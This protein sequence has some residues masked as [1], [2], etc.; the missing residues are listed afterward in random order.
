MAKKESWGKQFSMEKPNV[1]SSRERGPTGQFSKE[2][3]DLAK[4]YYQRIFDLRERIKQGIFFNVTEYP[5]K[6]GEGELE[7]EY[8]IPKKSLHID[9]E[10]MEDIFQKLNQLEEEIQGNSVLGTDPQIRG[11][12]LRK[13]NFIR[14]GLFQYLDVMSWP[15]GFVGDKRKKE[16]Q[17]ARDFLVESYFQLAERKE[18]GSDEKLNLRR[19]SSLND[20]LNKITL[21]LYRAK[22][23]NYGNNFGLGWIGGPDP[24]KLISRLEPWQG[25]LLSEKIYEYANLAGKRDEEL[26]EIFYADKKRR[27][28]GWA[29]MEFFQKA[30]STLSR[31]GEALTGDIKPDDSLVQKM[32]AELSKDSTEIE[33]LASTLKAAKQEGNDIEYSQIKNMELEEKEVGSDLDEKEKQ[34]IL[35][36][37]RENYFSDI[38][39][40][41]PEAAQGVIT[42]L[43]KELDDIKNQKAYILKY[44]GRIV[45]FFRLKLIGLNE[46]YAGSLNVYKDLQN[47]SIG[48]H[49][50]RAALDQE[51]RRN[52]IRAIIRSSNPAIGMYRRF[53]FEID[54][55]KPFE[56]NGVKYFN[57]AMDRRDK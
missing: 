57:M 8:Q 7:E 39:K 14:D 23:E 18:E 27:D 56:K 20:L 13:I 12:M 32:F 3:E 19:K 30:A 35:E 29:R 40:D 6:Y 25:R 45:A 36:I 55:E 47:L 33:I 54:E 44:Q 26:E 5:E 16:E 22:M 17:K 21:P 15:V 10:K 28:L 41:N 50:L 51:S 31:F 38:F 43:E 11:D 42:D 2:Q 37:A 46:L 34:E 4:D 24:E 48:T 52:V 1:A 53:G 49:F 9:T